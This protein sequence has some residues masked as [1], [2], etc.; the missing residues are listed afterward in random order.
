M[1]VVTTRSV[2]V[3]LDNETRAR[4]EKLSKSLRRTSHWLM[5]EAIQEYLGREEKREEFRQDAMR[6]WDEYQATG[7]HV[8]HNEA[9]DWLVKLEANQDVELPECHE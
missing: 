7:L 1:P 2:S 3:K 8:T 6:S 9:A 4:I 5:R